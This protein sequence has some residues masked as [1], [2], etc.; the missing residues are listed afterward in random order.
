MP[1]IRDADGSEAVVGRSLGYWLD[2]G[3]FVSTEHVEV[4]PRR[5]GA[6][7]FPRDW[8]AAYRQ[9]KALRALLGRHGALGATR[10]AVA[11]PPQAQERAQLPAELDPQPLQS[12]ANAERAAG[13]GAAGVGVVCGWAVYERLDLPPGTAFVAERYWWNALPG[14]SWVDITPR[15]QACERLLLAEA[16][17]GSAKC[18]M[19]LS[20]EQA[21]I[22]ERLLEQRFPGMRRPG[23]AVAARPAPVAPLPQP[24]TRP[25]PAPEE[26]PPPHAVAPV[27]G[28]APG[29]SSAPAPAAAA[30]QAAAAGARAGGGG[31]GGMDY[32]RFD[33]IEDS[34]DEAPSARQQA[35]TLPL[36]L[37]RDAVSRED[38]D[39]VWKVLLKRGELPFTPAPDLDGMWGFYKHGGMDEQA[40]LDQ[41]CEVLGGFPCRLEPADFKEKTYGLT[42][43]L[44]LAG[45]EDEARMWSAIYVCRFPKDPDGYYNQ[46]VLLNKMCD[47]AKF[48]GA[49][50]TRLPAL[51]GGPA[52]SVPT[53]QY[54]SLFS[55]AAVGYYRRCLEVDARQRPAYINLIG[56]LERNEPE[57]WYEDVQALA[58]RAVRHGI[59]YDRWQRPP[60]FVP[61]LPARPWHDPA[62]FGLCRAL[63]EHAETIRGEYDAYI[64]RLVRRRD[65][66]DADTTPGPGDVGARDGALH[67]GGLRKSGRWREVP[68][69]ANCALQREYAA[70]FPQTVAVL[71]AH[72]ADAVGLALCGGGDVIFSVLT[73]GTRLRPHC[74]PSNS[75]LTC[76]LG[77]RVPRTEEQGCWV[78]VAAEA[79]RG[80]R[81]GRCLVFD[82]SFEHEVTY[83]E[84]GP[85]EAFAGERVV[86]LANFWHPSFKF[87]NDPEWRA[88]S[89]V[90]MAQVEVESLPQTAVAVRAGRPGS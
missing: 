72:C 43:K 87:K 45:R 49:P 11:G 61:T 17:G 23:A 50:A 37:P 75:R 34:D 33:R 55:R 51:D 84:P 44:E 88:K 56:T 39:G 9:S 41:A 64:D 74:G 66:D 53:E 40:L 68:L 15:P 25:G 7:G 27:P 79:P 2:G 69:F 30:A 32:S 81:E 22:A 59:W 70:H 65:W 38:Y 90:T 77:V 52:R 62:G 46:G 35:L 5:L 82:D 16:P 58:Q 60:H 26:A 10:V 19:A 80:W 18:R 78:R 89:D 57:G 20:A 8:P 13:D 6:L 31:G 1:E 28:R 85:G 86:L 47:R 71:Q 29:A 3:D 48:G 4:D 24:G 14:G 76:H 42:K 12:F 73:P 54:C 67:D 83:G 63:E 21:E 36:G